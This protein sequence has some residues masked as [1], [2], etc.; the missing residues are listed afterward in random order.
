VVGHFGQPKEN[1]NW[2]PHL[3][4]QVIKDIRIKDGDYPGVCATSEKKK[5]L[6]NCPDAD[7]ILN[8]MKYCC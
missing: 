3:H 8:M 6:T 4:F 2:P 7:L 5:Y 1:G